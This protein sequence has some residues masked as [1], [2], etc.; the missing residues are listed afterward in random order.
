MKAS[1]LLMGI[2]TLLC[3]MLFASSAFAGD[4]IVDNPSFEILPGD[5]TFYGCGAGCSYDVAGIPG[6]AGVGSFGQFL[7]GSSSGNFAYFNYVPNGVTVA[8]SNGG[9]ISQI[10]GATVQN[11]VTYT[12]TVDIGDRNDGYPYV[13]TADLMLGTTPCAAAGSAPTPGNW[14]VFTATCIGTSAEE[15]EDGGAITIQLNSVGDQG[16]FDAVALTDSVSTIPEPSTLTLFG[17]GLLAMAYLFR[18]KR[19]TQS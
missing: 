19:F 6:W 2:P 17:S 14:S 11:G 15:E 9:T 8:Y 13:G 18:R 5:A 16:D 12:L 7:P 4:V 10:V 1:T 3:A